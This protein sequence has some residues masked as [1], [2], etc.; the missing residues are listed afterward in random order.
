MLNVWKGNL[1]LD[2]GVPQNVYELDEARMTQVKDADGTP[3]TLVVKP[4]ETVELPDGL[5][6]LTFNGLPRFVALDLRH[7]PALPFVLVFA[8][9][10]FAGLATSLFAPRRRLWLRF[11]PG[12]GERRPAVQ[13]SPR[14][15]WRAATTSASSPSSTRVLAETLARTADRPRP[16]PRPDLRRGR[17]HD[18]R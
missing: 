12:A 14:P 13:W 11:A 5:G 8:L 1:G 3:V 9:L 15:G 10:A 17:I 2:T 18:H 4:G 7:D 16:P 6:T